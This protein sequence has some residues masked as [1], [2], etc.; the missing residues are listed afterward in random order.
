[1]TKTTRS[2]FGGI[3]VALAVALGL[4]GCSAIKLGYNNLPDLAYWWLD[5]YLDFHDTQ[6]PQVRDEL[7]RLHTWHRQQELPRIA[8]VLARMEQAAAGPVTAPQVCAFAA[9]AQARLQAVADQA[10]GAVVQ[11]AGGLD[12]RQLRHLE[13]KYRNNKQEWRRDWVHKTLPEQREKR[14]EQFLDRAEMIYGTLPEPQRVVLR[15]A[16]EDSRFDAQRILADRERRQ[17]DLLKTLRRV[18]EA[19]V[20]PGTARSLMRGYFERAIASPDVT[21]RRYQQELI[22]ESCRTAAALHNATAPAQREQ[23][24]RRLR[25]YQR[26]VAELAARR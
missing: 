1:M 3:I 10:E 26:D 8:E 7:S 16:L 19:D 4:S 9:D 13:R 15:R 24:V 25:A 6:A 2:R 23:A 5:G 20:P 14:F 17:Q 21:Y 12:A 11:L 22:E 18:S